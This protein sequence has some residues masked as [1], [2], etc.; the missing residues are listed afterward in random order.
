VGVFE[1][2]RGPVLDRLFHVA[3]ARL[4]VLDDEYRLRAQRGR[5][6]DDRNGR[7]RRD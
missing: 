4:C 6:G 7:D 3:L 2:D 5:P 1:T